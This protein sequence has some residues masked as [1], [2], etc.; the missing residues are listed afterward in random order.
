MLNMAPAVFI[1]K[2]KVSSCNPALRYGARKSRAYTRQ[3]TIASF[4]V[5]LL[6]RTSG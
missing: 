6:P 1:V 3:S 2:Y 5:P 4:S